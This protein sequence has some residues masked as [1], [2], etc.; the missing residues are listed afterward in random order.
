MADEL[1]GR[2]GRALAV[3]GDV[4]DPTVAEKLVDACCSEFGA[5]HALVANAGIVRTKS[6]LETSDEDFDAVLRVH[7]YGTFRCAR[8]AA[9]RMV[10]QASG[11]AIVNTT[12][13][14]LLGIPGQASYAAAKA[15]IAA[16]TWNM[17]WELACHGIRVNAIAPTGTTEMRRS[18]SPPDEPFFDPEL[19]APVVVLLCSDEGRYVTG[20]ILA[21]GGDRL[22]LLGGLD[23]R[24]SMQRDGGWSLE[25]LR[26]AFPEE[27]GRALEPFG[28]ER[29]SDGTYARRTTFPYY[30][31]PEPQESKR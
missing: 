7:L 16:L 22:S 11:G 31:R 13:T 25:A 9:R 1:R 27:I 5:I 17:A 23:V 29:Q 26:E 2:G 6:F 10:E 24:R 14:A 28:I 3:W 30:E 18:G 4:A 15:G 20:Q 19:N 8:A 21:T 12:S